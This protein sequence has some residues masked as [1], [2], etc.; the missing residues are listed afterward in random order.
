MVTTHLTQLKSLAFTRPEVANASMEFD[1]ATHL[2][3]FR[4]LA[5]IPGSSN[6]LEMAERFGLPE[7]VLAAARRYMHPDWVRQDALLKK[8]QALRQEEEETL[9]RLRER[10]RE[11]EAA[12]D[13][14]EREAAE[15]DR[16]WRREREE[17]QKALWEE[18]HRQVARLR[19][20]GIAVGKRKEQSAAEALVPPAPPRPAAEPAPGPL[21]TGQ[22]VTVRSL[23]KEGRVIRVQAAEGTA[24]VE[25]GGKHFWFPLEDL[26]AEG[27]RPS[28]APRSGISLPSTEMGYPELNLIGLR[29]EEAEEAMERFLSHAALTGLRQV[30]MVHGHGT[31][32]LRRGVRAFL[33]GHALVQS[34]TAGD[35]DATTVVEVRV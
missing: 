24:V 31:G 9:G 29:V 27:L 12:R 34:F 28:A 17:L 13:R 15:R 4:F 19:E 25:V 35:R 3:T 23:N 21:A 26:A 18:L 7:G 33:K 6:A 20:E 22:A 30:V 32:R 10:E 8:I 11:A 2:P 16:A 14:A 5:D 1:E